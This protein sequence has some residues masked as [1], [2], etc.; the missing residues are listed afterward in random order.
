MNSLPAGR[1]V[2]SMYQQIYRMSPLNVASLSHLTNTNVVISLHTNTEDIS[3]PLQQG[4]QAVSQVVAWLA[5]LSPQH[6]AEGRRQRNFPP[7]NE[8]VVP[9]IGSAQPTIV[10]QCPGKGVVWGV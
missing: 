1:P 2:A 3:L 7:G 8:K 4:R 10:A 9:P 6:R 5:A